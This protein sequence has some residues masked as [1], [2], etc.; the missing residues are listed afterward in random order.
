MFTKLT[1]YLINRYQRYRLTFTYLWQQRKF[2][3]L[4][5]ADN[6]RRRQEVEEHGQIGASKHREHR[7]S[8]SNTVRTFLRSRA[9]KWENKMVISDDDSDSCDEDGK[10]SGLWITSWNWQSRYV[11]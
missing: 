4:S 5:F 11:P 3:R 10:E 7:K 8:S 2:S 6:R 1:I 9:L